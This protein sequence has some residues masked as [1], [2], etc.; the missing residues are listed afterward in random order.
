M[1]HEE[2]YYQNLLDLL[3]D[4]YIDEIGY[5]RVLDKLIRYRLSDENIQEL[6]FNL[7]DIKKERRYIIF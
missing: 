3:I 4:D 7:E 1:K 5:T 2:I 6:G